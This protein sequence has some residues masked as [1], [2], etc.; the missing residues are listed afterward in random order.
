MTMKTEKLDR[1][2]AAEEELVPSS[3][4]LASVMERVQEE[5]ATPA[6]IPFPWKRVVVGI[7]IVVGLLG[8]CSVEMLRQG[9]PNPHWGALIPHFSFALTRPMEGLGWVSAAL[10]ISLASWLLSKRMMGRSE[11]L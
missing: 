7:V 8:W 3:G 4:F 1:I 10:G 5:A 2:L 9:L 11:L 6:P